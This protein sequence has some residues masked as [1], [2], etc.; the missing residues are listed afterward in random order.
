MGQT[1][2]ETTTTVALPTTTQMR[3]ETIAE[4]FLKTETQTTK[5]LN[6]NATIEKLSIL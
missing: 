2:E 3:M 5:G 1:T 4:V 6:V